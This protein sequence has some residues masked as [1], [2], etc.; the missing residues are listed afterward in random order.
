MT[1]AAATYG[2]STLGGTPNLDTDV[3][4]RA[5][6]RE[7]IRVITVDERTLTRTIRADKRELML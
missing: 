7:L 4:S 6:E 3:T 2:G 1:Y 5:R